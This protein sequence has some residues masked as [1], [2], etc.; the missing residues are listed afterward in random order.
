MDSELWNRYNTCE[1][2]VRGES[3]Y[4]NAFWYPVKITLVLVIMVEGAIL[5]VIV[6]RVKFTLQRFSIL[7]QY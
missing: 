5:L 1:L 3:I 7:V 4:D 2:E 6:N